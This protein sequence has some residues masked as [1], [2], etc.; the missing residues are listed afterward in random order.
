MQGK[1][2]FIPV[3]FDERTGDLKATHWA[4]EPVLSFLIWVHQV[5]S[6]ILGLLNID[7]ESDFP[8]TFH[9]DARP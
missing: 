4:L 6:A 2:Y 3:V 8:I 7:H 9:K 5:S 1:F